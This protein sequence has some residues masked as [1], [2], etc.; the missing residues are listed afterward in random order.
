[1]KNWILTLSLGLSFL[2]ILHT[3]KVSLTFMYYYLNT[4][5]FIEM[6]CENKDKPELQC[7][8]Q[9]HLKTVSESSD[10]KSNSPNPFNLE[11]LQL[12]N[13]KIS[14]YESYTEFFI[15]EKISYFYL[16]LYRFSYTKSCFHPPQV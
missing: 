11:D 3:L 4:N 14:S 7:N 5:S 12:F 16:N 10:D 13:Q 2:I 1:M 9:C 8:G 6:F 15:S